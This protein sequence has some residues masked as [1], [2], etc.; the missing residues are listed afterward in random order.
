MGADRHGFEQVLARSGDAPGFAYHLSHA[1]GLG[2]LAVLAVLLQT[3]LVLAND[4]TASLD[5]GGLTLTFNPDISMSQRI[6]T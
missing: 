5:A 1:I 3:S 4:S 2:A 6:S